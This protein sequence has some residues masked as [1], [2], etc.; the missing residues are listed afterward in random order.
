MWA[1]II[2]FF[3]SLKIIDKIV[4]FFTLI[5]KR[6]QQAKKVKRKNTTKMNKD[7]RRK[8]LTQ[9]EKEGLSDEEIKDLFRDLHK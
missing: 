6:Y 5:D 1:S 7:E 4:D 9:L 2:A 8:T 3:S